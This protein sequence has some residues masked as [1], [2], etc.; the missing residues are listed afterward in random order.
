MRWR[1]YTKCIDELAE[2]SERVGV[3]LSLCLNYGG[4]SMLHPKYCEMIRYASETKRFSLRAITNATLLTPEIAET[5]VKH[6]PFVTVS[7]HNSS[8]TAK[9]YDN[10]AALFKLRGKNLRPAMVG[11]IV[12]NEFD[13]ANLILQLKRW[14]P[15]LD[16]VTVYP[17]FTEQLKYV[18]WEKPEGIT[19]TDPKSY[20]AILWDGTV[21][22]CCHL[23]SL[24]KGQLPDT[25][26][27]GCELI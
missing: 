27:K 9:A 8:E 18:D 7:I 23:F 21:Y 12:Q 11:A 2:Y 3:R 10:V 15:I 25:P 19:C 17:V 6:C 20:I 5:L 13:P 26:C 1:L 4:E 16:D 14:T 24:R 22:P